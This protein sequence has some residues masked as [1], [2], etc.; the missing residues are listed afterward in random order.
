MGIFGLEGVLNKGSFHLQ[1][2]AY[3]A[4]YRGRL[5]GYGGGAYLQVGWY[6]TGDKRNYDPRW[7]LISPH[8][9]RSKP[10]VELLARVSHTRGEDDLS[11]WND[12]KSL[13]LGANVYY[14]KVR[15]SINFLYG[16]SR[17][18]INGEDSGFGVN[19]RFQYIF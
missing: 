13:T 6:V 4:G 11:G 12:F 8:T 14:R 15:G 18:P 5:D 16:E 1:G 7:G 3:A 9:P 19:V 17:E 2:E 10:S